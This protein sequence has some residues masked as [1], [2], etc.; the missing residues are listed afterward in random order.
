[1]QR[2]YLLLSLIVSGAIL[3]LALTACGGQTNTGKETT[4]SVITAKAQALSTSES[5]AAIEA[6]IIGTPM[7]IP[8]MI[9]IRHECLL[10]HGPKG[11]TQIP[12]PDSHIG[13]SQDSCQHCMKVADN[14]YSTANTYL[15]V[16]DTSAAATTPPPAGGTTTATISASNLFAAKCS[17][18]HGANRQGVSGFAPAL[19]QANL[20]SMT[21]TQITDTIANGR[22]STAMMSF[23]GSLS[24][25]Q[26]TALVQF[27]K[28][29]QP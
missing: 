16:T 4:G 18:C 3:M 5:D 8:N 27:V 11:E 13:L 9:N 6:K 20:A 23:K 25:D 24:P 15:T 29:P 12:Y 7:R 1:M 26:I 28:S 22:P 17:A 10:C 2:K 14:A 19:T 21:D